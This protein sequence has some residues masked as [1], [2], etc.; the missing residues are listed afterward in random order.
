MEFQQS[1]LDLKIQVTPTDNYYKLI[2]GGKSMKLETIE[3]VSGDAKKKSV[4]NA[5][6]IDT[7]INFTNV[8]LEKDQLYLDFQYT[9][10]YQPDESHLRLNGTAMFSGPE[11]KKLFEEWAKTKKMSGKD[12]ETILNAINYNAS[13]NAVLLSK[14][15][16][17]LPPIV[18]P[19]L[20]FR[21]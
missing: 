18:L 5:K 13:I 8:Q 3:I 7:S 14:V 21:E 15:F 4:E 1:I 19:T 11:T 17:L 12:G 10:L 9:V 6:K 16:N 20:S 2:I